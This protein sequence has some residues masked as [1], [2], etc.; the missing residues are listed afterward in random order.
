MSSDHIKLVVG[1]LA[2]AA[3]AAAAFASY[4]RSR[5]NESEPTDARQAEEKEAT[6]EETPQQFMYK[7]GC[8]ADQY[9][10]AETM[11]LIMCGLPGRGK[12]AIANRTAQY[13]RFFHGLECEV[14]SVA[15]KRRE[16]LGY[17]DEAYY[18][19]SNPD[20]VS[21]RRQ[22]YLDTLDSLKVASVRGTSAFVP[23]MSFIVSRLD[24]SG[25][26]GQERAGGN[27]RRLE[28]DAGAAA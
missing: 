8:I 12:T 16:K 21:L 20:T 3:V 6:T 2:A 27:L 11:A 18:D 17:R 26:D 5:V 25:G 4:K 15:A 14:F 19:D 13:L 10:T 9:T 22:F 24:V 23:S 7:H 1:S 28:R